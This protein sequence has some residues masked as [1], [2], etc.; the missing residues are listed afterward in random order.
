[1]DFNPLHLLKLLQKPQS[2]AAG[3]YAGLIRMVDPKAD[4][5]NKLGV[6]RNPLSGF[7]AGLKGDIDPASALKYS[8]NN[9]ANNGLV[10]KAAGLVENV[11]ADPLNLLGPIAKAGALGKAG[12]AAATFGKL[13]EDASLGEK[14]AQF[15]RRFH[16][17]MLATGD[18]IMGLGTGLLGGQ[19]ESRVLPRLE[20]IKQLL[21]RTPGNVD[22]LGT[23]I[24]GI[25]P[26]AL[27]MGRLFDP[28]D[29]ASIAQNTGTPASGLGVVNPKALE[30]ALSGIEQPSL[31][32]TP[33]TPKLPSD[34]TSVEEELM[35]LLRPKPKVLIDPMIKDQDIV[36]QILSRGRG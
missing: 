23:A 26:N 2:M 15:G 1:M 19:V 18:P 4:E 22:E 20:A 29:V 28:A 33:I 12:E 34:A 17:G 31:F 30:S 6:G 3:T 16:Q 7:M 10:D 9:Y 21:M 8:A 5:Q 14:A 24:S 35:K 32:D 36:S 11:G 13:G 27:E 25:E